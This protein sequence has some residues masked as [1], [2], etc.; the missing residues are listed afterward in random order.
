MQII[1][2]ER[3]IPALS[4]T[5]SEIFDYDRLRSNKSAQ[6]LRPK[7]NFSFNQ[8]KEF[9]G[10]KL[11]IDQFKFYQEKCENIKLTE[12]SKYVGYS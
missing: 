4:G 9:K 1:L 3:K 12:V 2:K 8:L 11:K 6:M 7:N 5:S 10:K